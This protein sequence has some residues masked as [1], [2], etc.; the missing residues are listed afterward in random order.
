MEAFYIAC[1]VT[2]W[3]QRADLTQRDPGHSPYHL[4][5]VS[6]L[7]CNFTSLFKV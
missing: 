6:S 7:L 3:E 4:H 1:N 2:A 5:I